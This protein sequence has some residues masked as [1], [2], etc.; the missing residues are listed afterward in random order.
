MTSTI[1]VNTIT[2][3]SGS[4]LTVGGCGKTVALASGASQ[5]GFGRTGTVNW[6]TGSIKTS[7]FTAADG[8]GY[9][10]DTSSGAFTMNLPAGSA[11]AIVAVKDYANTFDSQNLTITPNGS[12][13]IG[14][15]TG[16]YPVSV[17]GL[18]LTLI[19]LDSTRGWIDIHESTQTSSGTSFICASV[20]GACNTLVTADTNF[21]VATFVGPG[22]FTVNSGGGSL[23]K[24]DYMV[25]AGGGGGGTRYGGGGGAGG[26]RESKCSTTS[27][28]W[29]AS[30]RATCV[31]LDV[32]P[33]AI[34]VTVGAGGAGSATQ[35]SGGN[36]TRGTQGGTSTFSTISSAGGGGG[37]SENVCGSAPNRR[38]G[39]AGGSGGGA[40]Y[41]GCGPADYAQGGA[42][43]TPS[44]NPAQGFAGGNGGPT[45][46]YG[47]GGG[48]GATAVGTNGSSPNTTGVGGAG[49][50]NTINGTPTQRGGGGGGAGTQD[51]IPTGGAGGAGGGGAGGPSPNG[52]A[53]A[54]TA[55]TGGGAGGGRGNPDTSPQTTPNGGGTGGS[56]IVI[57]R[58]KF[59]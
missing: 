9:F 6:Q 49:A 56:G 29:T 46:G 26:Y 8:E 51:G 38:S 34:P 12:D 33:G 22:T 37:S 1:K 27:G 14:G 41:N 57:I 20:S 52:V 40:S 44:T 53:T 55:N 58:Y 18:S 36:T 30:P 47:A 11:G 28:C 31:S 19:F 43:N 50:T 13:K 25:V 48:G 2:T 42:G 7:T 3:E 5:T 39:G 32:V 24:I 54:G 4:T 59:Q 17:E 10:A 21:K 16:N 35:A 23:A 45:S 15:V